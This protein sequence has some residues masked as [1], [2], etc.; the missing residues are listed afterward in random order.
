MSKLL[1]LIMLNIGILSSCAITDTPESSESF[2]ANDSIQIA[3][4]VHSIVKQ[5][6]LSCDTTTYQTGSIQRA[7]IEFLH[8]NPISSIPEL[9]EKLFQEF[10]TLIENPALI[11]SDT[12]SL[13]ME[14]ILME[15][16]ILSQNEKSAY[17]NL[18][19]D[20]A[21]KKLNNRI[22]FVL[23]NPTQENTLRI[24]NGV[25]HDLNKKT[26]EDITP[27]TSTIAH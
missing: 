5:L 10:E 19:R 24:I 12:L 18:P 6:D 3:A 8:D 21:L 22:Y 20:K 14:I 2:S 7:Q 1:F 26:N 25:I 11:S 16:K 13:Y 23:G 27:D 9:Q 4:T 17:Y 15:L